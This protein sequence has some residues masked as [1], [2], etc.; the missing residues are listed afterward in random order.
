METPLQQVERLV[1][2]LDVLVAREAALL[3]MADWDEAGRV[4]ERMVVLVDAIVP[5][6]RSLHAD[7]TM[8]RALQTR[9]EAIMARQRAALDLFRANLQRVKAELDNARTAQA[10]LGSVR[11]VY[12]PPVKQARATHQTSVFSAQG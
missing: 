11:P 12:F 8:P 9:L 1:Q 10:R 2:A 6:A 7:G 3:K 4:K 5:L